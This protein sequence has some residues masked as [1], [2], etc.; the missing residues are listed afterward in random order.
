MI[1]SLIAFVLFRHIFLRIT[2]R[3]QP[4]TK[5]LPPKTQTL[6]ANHLASFLHAVC[7]SYLVLSTFASHPDLLTD[8]QGLKANHWALAAS[9]TTVAFSAG[10]FIADCW[11]MAVTGVYGRNLGIW[12]HHIVTVVCYSAALHK[13]ALTP[14]LVL[15]LL[16]E[17]NSIFI[18]V[19]K[20]LVL[21][22]NGFDHLP[23]TA[24]TAY[25]FATAG[26]SATYVPTRILANLYITYQVGIQDRPNWA[27]PAYTW[28][29]AFLGMVLVNYY[30]VILWKQ[31]RSTLRKEKVALA[32]ASI[33]KD[34]D[35]TADAPQGA[36]A[37]AEGND[38]G[39]FLS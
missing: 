37:E 7:S 31:L 22:Y 8:L 30:N 5:H 15:T 36:V 33:K 11:D 34:D 26:L 23:A 12:A 28:W 20:I 3:Q 4:A 29:M 9:R 24:A 21:F 2:L 13:C 1:S 39:E 18:H 16:V 35:A 19:R 17:F 10:Y 38:A 6:L 25:K 14:Y 32:L 27:F